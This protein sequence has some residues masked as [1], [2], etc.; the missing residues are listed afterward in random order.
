MLSDANGKHNLEMENKRQK[1]EHHCYYITYPI[2]K[3]A[4]LQLKIIGSKSTK[5]ASQSLVKEKIYR[6]IKSFLTFWNCNYII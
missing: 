5:V 4:F 6:S 2:V 1:F 3:K